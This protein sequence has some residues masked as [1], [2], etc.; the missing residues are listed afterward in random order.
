MDV[1]RQIALEERRHIPLEAILDFHR[2]VLQSISNHGRTHKIDIMLRFKA[3]TGR[4]LQD[5][6]LGIRMLAHRKLD[7]TPSR[8]EDLRE[9]QQ[10]FKRHWEP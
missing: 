4:W 6:N 2:A 5:L 9:I 10:I 3:A 8:V 1:L 7:L